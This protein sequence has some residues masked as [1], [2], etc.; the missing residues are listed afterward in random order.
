MLRR[1]NT[2]PLRS[3]PPLGGDISVIVSDEA[4][5]PVTTTPVDQEEANKVRSLVLCPSHLGSKPG[6][7]AVVVISAWRPAMQTGN[8][9]RLRAARLRPALFIF[10]L[11]Y[12][13]SSARVV[14]LEW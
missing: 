13:R 6:L 7:P 1:A 2:R 4:L 10:V 12:W 8:V 3:M 9:T 11:Q 14:F 5:E